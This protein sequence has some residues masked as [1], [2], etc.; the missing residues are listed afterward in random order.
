MKDMREKRG[1]ISGI[2]LEDFFGHIADSNPFN[3]NRVDDPSRLYVDVDT[4]HQKAFQRLIAH[5]ETA[6]KERCGIGVLL[7]GEAG[8]GKSHLLA[9]LCHWAEE[10]DRA[11]Y[12]FLHNL[13]SSPERLPRYIL[14]CVVSRLTQGKNHGF[15][16]T[17]LY[18]LVEKMAAPA[19]QRF[20]DSS[21]KT[22]KTTALKK[23][24]EKLR[25]SLMRIMNFKTT[26]LERAYEK[27]VDELIDG[28]PYISSTID[29][30]IYG[31]LIRFFFSSYFAYNG[32]GDDRQA[33]WAVR[34][35]MGDELDQDEAK[36]LGVPIQG[37][38]E[39]AVASLP[40]N[41]AVEQ[42]LVALAQL[43]RHHNQPFIICFDQVDNMEESQLDALIRFIHAL[44]DHTPNLL[45]VTSGVKNTLLKYLDRGV[46]SQAAWDRIAAEELQLSRITAEEA[47]Q[48]LTARLESF[49]GPFLTLPEVATKLK[50]DPL[51]P[52]SEPWFTQKIENLPR[53][54]PREVISWA[55]VRW[56]EE[57]ESLE[58]KGGAEWLKNWPHPV[59]IT[60]PPP[61]EEL[62][63]NLV[64]RKLK[65]QMSQREL[66]SEGLPPDASNIAGLLQVLLS[67]CLTE[68]AR[69]TSLDYILC[70]VERPKQATKGSQPAYH[71]LVEE[72][73]SGDGKR[74]RTGITVLATHS[75][76]SAASTLKRMAEDKNQ[77]DH[78]L[79]ITDVRQGLKLATKGK[80]YHKA[81][82]TL[83]Q[84][85]FK[86][87]ELTFSEY[88]MLDALQAVVGEGRSGDLEVEL[89]DGNTQPVSEQE[90]IASH[91]RRDRYRQHPLLRELLTEELPHEVPP[92]KPI[93]INAQDLRQFIMAQLAMTMG[94]S[95]QEVA[96]K[97]HHAH[98]IHC[99][100]E[101]LFKVVDEVAKAM[102]SEGLIRA[103][104]W[105]DQLYLTYREVQ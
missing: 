43:A 100:L 33:Q 38:S 8:I 32:K 9:R 42:V 10:K 51:F 77:P 105:D 52:L 21:K 93:D 45:V 97:Y 59:V 94:M 88:L 44:L 16:G 20:G 75:A 71:L 25:L 102:H 80:E 98:K 1:G 86:Q 103:Q 50:T 39:E 40:D 92:V 68:K 4:I 36:P 5:A 78:I 31:V 18:R 84:G 69:H 47:K 54:R 81:L 90:V 83:G 7:G 12:V 62:I 53:F 79:L 26:A 60:P 95:S 57:K 85:C 37:A 15:F 67:Q 19:I 73:R 48:L 72:E 28:N 3:T 49:F 61:L 29:R 13:Q 96:K 66:Y 14:K 99:E 11:F 89:A 63:D 30:L 70:R 104:P 101:A 55:K 46:I 35:L 23:A 34:W 41:Q 24:Y 6:Y 58:K 17:P 2:T 64:E 91:H 27:R 82:V 22:V 56:R 87:H 74:M 76:I 65:S